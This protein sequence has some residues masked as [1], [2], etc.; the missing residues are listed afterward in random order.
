MED[1]ERRL[2]GQLGGLRWALQDM[3]DGEYFFGVS[4]VAKNAQGTI[5]TAD[6]GTH[7][8]RKEHLQRFVADFVLALHRLETQAT[9][10]KEEAA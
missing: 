8:L 5:I 7:N 6:A 9:T 2:E 3:E 4:I 10:Q 1:K